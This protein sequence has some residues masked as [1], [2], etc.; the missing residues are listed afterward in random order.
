MQKMQETCVVRVK[1]FRPNYN[2]LRE[3]CEDDK[4]MY[5]GRKGIVFGTA[6]KMFYNYLNKQLDDEYKTKI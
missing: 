1:D 5:I 4:N 3:W 2:N 6:C